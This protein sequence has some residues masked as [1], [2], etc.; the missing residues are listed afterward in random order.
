M[1]KSKQNDNGRYFEFLITKQLH[2][3][4]H[5]QLTE[6]ARND[7]TRDQE[8]VIEEKTLREMISASAKIIKWL[9]SELELNKDSTLDRLPD[10]D[11]SG[12]SHADI[13]ISHS[14]GKK[15][16]FSLKHNH[17]AVFHGRIVAC[18]SWPGVDSKS[19]I[20]RNFNQT[21]KDLFLTL[22]KTIPI[23]TQFAD[24]GIYNEYRDVWSEF[25]YELHEAAKKFLI[26]ACQD[27]RNTQNLFRTIMGAGSDEFRV[28][29]YNKKVIVQDLRSLLLPTS[30]KISNTQKDSDKDARSNYVWHLVFEFNNGIVIDARNKQDS[31]FM[32]VTPQLKSDWQVLDWGSSGMTEKVLD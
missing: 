29:K 24:G 12:S 19:S 26:D 10:K 9:G 11:Q 21:K 5:L 15:V 4:N 18:T 2:E 22:Q 23:G 6:R 8:K 3:D 7:Q 20:A 27:K 32:K 1:S 31:R 17:Y 30:V 28:L 14:N 25:V 16:S 13:S